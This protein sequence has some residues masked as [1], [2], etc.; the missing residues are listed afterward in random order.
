MKNGG[1]QHP[2]PFGL[3]LLF[4]SISSTLLYAQAPS[5][6]SS[7]LEQ[8][9]GTVPWHLTQRDYHSQVWESSV[10]SLDPVTGRTNVQNHSFVEIGSGINFLDGNGN[11]QS[12]RPE[13]QITAQGYAVGQFGPHQLIVEMTNLN[14]TTAI[15]FLAYDGTR[16][17]L[18][19]VSIAW[20]DPLL[21]TNYTLAIVQDCAGTMTATNQ[22]TF[23]NCFQG[24]G[25]RASIRVSYL[26]AGISQD[27]LLHEV[28]DPSAMG[29][30]KFVR[31]ELYSELTP[32]SPVPAQNTRV[33]QSPSTDELAQTKP[34]SELLL[35]RFLDWG[36]YTMPAGSAFDLNGNTGSERLLVAKRYF[37]TPDQRPIILEAIQW[38]EAS[39]LFAGL[40]PSKN[41]S[42]V[43]QEAGWRPAP[44]LSKAAS[45]ERGIHSAENST[46]ALTV[47]S[48]P[49][50]LARAIPPRQPA[51]KPVQPLQE[52]TNRKATP[53]RTLLADWSLITG[54]TNVT[55]AGNRTF[56]V[57]SS[58]HLYGQTVI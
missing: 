12:T 47:G 19:P 41:G 39:S 31:L 17:R 20:F 50:L 30:S 9:A 21:S 52:A 51:A 32:D 45:T 57:G 26:K 16:L 58:L 1:T 38:S 53:D 10:A 18:G 36:A 6:S 46:P 48:S 24:N 25:L 14:S 15:D 33:V 35:A 55:L 44:L 54:P 2:V 40:G 3:S 4:L 29:F 23:S 56:F 28:P 22:I 27:L 43:S 37:V 42:R 8:S 13:L 5:P 11:W 34:D 7:P 49:K